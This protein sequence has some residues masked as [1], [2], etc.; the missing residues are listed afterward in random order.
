MW[1]KVSN[2]RRMEKCMLKEFEE[3]NEVSNT[4]TERE[5][6]WYGCFSRQ[7]CAFFT[8]LA[9]APLILVNLATILKHAKQAFSLDLC[10]LNLGNVLNIDR[11]LLD[12]LNLA[13]A[14]PTQM[15]CCSSPAGQNFSVFEKKGNPIT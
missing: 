14:R 4:F 6:F 11:I 12:F 3:V 1:K 7:P 5:D 8:W 15:F 9:T 13:K 10:C 2:V